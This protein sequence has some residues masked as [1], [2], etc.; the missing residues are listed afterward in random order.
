MSSDLTQIVKMFDDLPSFTTTME[1]WEQIDADD[2]TILI[3]IAVQKLVNTR[4]TEIAS[5]KAENDSLRAKSAAFDKVMEQESV[6]Y[7]HSRL[8]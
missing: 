4:D 5:L 2:D 6:W 3:S 1:Q 8:R 7:A